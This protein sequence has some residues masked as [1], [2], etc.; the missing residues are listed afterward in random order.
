MS[1]LKPPITAELIWAED[2]KFGATSGSSAMVIDGDSTAGPS[3][4][5]A[6]AIALAGCMAVDV[7]MMLQKGRHPLKGLRASVS[8][9]RAPSPPRG[10]TRIALTYHVTGSVPPDAVERAIALSRHTY[11]SVWQSMRKDIELTTAFE[12]HS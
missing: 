4:M 5:Q 2:L 10:F 12:I 11:C 6:L 8:G 9:E 3:P 7:V 1:D